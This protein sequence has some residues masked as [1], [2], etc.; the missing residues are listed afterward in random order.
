LQN[1]G[2]RKFCIESLPRGY[3]KEATTS[4]NNFESALLSYELTMKKKEHQ[5]E[6]ENRKSKLCP[7]EWKPSGYIVF[8]SEFAKSSIKKQ[9]KFLEKASLAWNGLSDEEKQTYKSKAEKM[10]TE[11]ISL[12]DYELTTPPFKRNYYY[13]RKSFP[14]FLFG[15][16]HT[17]SD[18]ENSKNS[19]LLWE[20]AL[21]AWKSLSSF[22]KRVI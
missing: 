14:L 10:V 21:S 5:L 17:F 9:T 16:V 2:F 7:K 20:N 6:V 12:S 13:A 3:V 15:Y 4:E 1:A 8:I 22:E 18:S 11:M 19:E